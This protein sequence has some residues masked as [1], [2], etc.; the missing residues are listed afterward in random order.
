MSNGRIEVIAGGMFGG[1]STELVRRLICAQIARKKVVAFKH[2]ADDRYDAVQIG[3]HN[4]LRFQATPVSTSAEIMALVKADPEIRVVGI[5]EGQFFDDDLPEVCENMANAGIRV[6][7]A[8]LDNDSKGKPF[9]PIPYLMAL[10]E[11]VDKLKAV[12]MVCGEPACRSQHK[13]G[14]AAQVEV[15]ADAYEAR[16]RSCWT[17]A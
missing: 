5:D 15:G 8:A 16:C 2:A 14:K 9:G 13:A 3:C 17:P 12:C 7:V 11:D 10:A 6:I 4:G 1:K